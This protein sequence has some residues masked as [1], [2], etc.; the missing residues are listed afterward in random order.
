MWVSSVDSLPDGSLDD[1]DRMLLNPDEIEKYVKLLTDRFEFFLGVWRNVEKKPRTGRHSAP[2]I[3]ICKAKRDGCN[4]AINM[5]QSFDRDGVSST[6]SCSM[7]SVIYVASQRFVSMHLCSVNSAHNCYAH[8]S[9][10]SRNEDKVRKKEKEERE[11][12]LGGKGVKA[13]FVG[14]TKRELQAIVRYISYYVKTESF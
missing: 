9:Y 6:C 10:M 13:E 8:D 1:V 2:A 12:H 3:F 4:A 11:Q 5:S 7:Y 14:S